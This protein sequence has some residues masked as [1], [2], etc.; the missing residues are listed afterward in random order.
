MT[1]LHWL[2]NLFLSRF[3][4][5]FAFFV[6]YFTS[7]DLLLLLFLSALYTFS[8]SKYNLTGFEIPLLCSDWLLFWMTATDSDLFFK[9]V[10]VTGILD[11]LR[12]PS[13]VDSVPPIK[14]WQKYF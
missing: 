4:L 11:F 7:F 8:G 13:L 1:P 6:V 12:L 9:N 3:K 5:T 10:G 2:G 14:Q